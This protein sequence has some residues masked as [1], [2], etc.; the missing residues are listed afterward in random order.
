MTEDISNFSINEN[1]DI[2]RHLEKEK[3]MQILADSIPENTQIKDVL[4]GGLLFLADIIHQMDPDRKH[5]ILTISQN[6]LECEYKII[7][8][9]FTEH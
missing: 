1:G 3:V 7:Q 9:H 5:N 8:R 2:I 4:F 6:M